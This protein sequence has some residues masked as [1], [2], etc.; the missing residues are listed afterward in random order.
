[1]K[2]DAGIWLDDHESLREE[3]TF[4]ANMEL[5]AERWRALVD[6]EKARLSTRLSW[7]KRF[8]R[9]LRDIRRDFVLFYSNS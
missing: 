8:V 7:R 5:A 1:M 6:E 9:L 3:A 4:Q 2:S